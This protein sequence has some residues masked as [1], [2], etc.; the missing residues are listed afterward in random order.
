MGGASAASVL[1]PN[2]STW[3]RR[4]KPQAAAEQRLNPSVIN[5]R[6]NHHFLSNVPSALLIGLIVISVLIIIS[7]LV[8]AKRKWKIDLGLT[9]HAHSDS[10]THEFA[11]S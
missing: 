8:Y 10:N 3:S 7:L 1:D 11:G 5:T 4:Y 9:G 6:L 2:A